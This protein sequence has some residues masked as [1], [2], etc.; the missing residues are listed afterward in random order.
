MKTNTIQIG[1]RTFRVIHP[2]KHIVT[3]NEVVRALSNG[4]KSIYDAYDRP[5]HAKA[6][7]FEYW[8]DF[9][10]EHNL[11][12]LT[13]LSRNT[14]KFTLGAIYV[15]PEDHNTQYFIHITDCKHEAYLIH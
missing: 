2:R 11:Q 7:A 12:H 3:C 1:D 13:I 4:Y 5:S 10:N 14:F 8:S 15:S 9:A 6:L